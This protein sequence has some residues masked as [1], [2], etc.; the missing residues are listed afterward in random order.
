[1]KEEL[2]Y[3]K[4][5]KLSLKFLN[6]C[7]ANVYNI[8]LDE[9]YR[10]SQLLL[11]NLWID[12]GFDISLN[13]DTFLPKFI[14][15]SLF[16]KYNIDTWLS[17]RIKQNIGKQVLGIIKGTV[18]KQKKRLYILKKLKEEHK[19]KQAR[20][21]Q[22]I[23]D[24]QSI[25]KPECSNF[26]PLLNERCFKNIKFTDDICWI[27]ICSLKDR[28]IKTLKLAEDKP[29]HIDLCFKLTKHFNKL[30]KNSKLKNSIIL[31]RN[32]IQFSFEF[33]IPLNNN[34]NI[35]GIDIGANNVYT[36][37]NGQFDIP[38]NHGHTYKSICTKLSKQKKGSKNFKQT[39]KQRDQ[40]I[41]WLVK[42]IDLTNYKY[43]IHENIKNLYR[44]K[45]TSRI[46]KHFNYK[47]I[48]DVLDNYCKLFGV[49]VLT[50]NPKYTSQRCSLCGYVHSR[51][52][53]K[54]TVERFKCKFCGT[55]LNADLNASRNISLKLKSLTKKQCNG[56]NKIGFF[57]DEKNVFHCEESMVPHTSKV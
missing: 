9:Y 41:Q 57:W 4:S 1:M 5:T 37:S 24:N 33:E 6:N 8:F 14:D 28:K 3:I 16:Q 53:S 26:N 29:D 35:L 36:C 40:Y 15:V 48:F 55:E 56:L 19:F 39:A 20:K 12:F 34:T 49:Q 38:D 13:T 47:H 2:T 42:H 22:K 52:R 7:K 50:V 18:T 44:G 25:S 43:V 21:L 46:L 31:S 27:T 32:N 30:N 45:N 10:V 54:R 11:D 23:I 51:N 17:G